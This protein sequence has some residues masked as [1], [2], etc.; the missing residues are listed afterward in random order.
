MIHKS[1]MDYVKSRLERD[2]IERVSSDGNPVNDDT[3][4]GVVKTG[5]LQGDPD[6][7]VAR[8]SVELYE[9]DPDQEI[10][11][12]GI[13]QTSEA[14]QDRIEEIEIGGGITWRRRFTVKVRVL[15]E[16]TREDLDNARRI[17]STVRSRVEKSILQM[18]FAGVA[19]E[20]EMV[21]MGPFSDDLNS[22]MLQAGG[23]PDAYDF[24]IKIRFE[25]L[26]TQF[27][28]EE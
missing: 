21:V 4:A 24:F 17:A 25:V 26:T 2:L 6:P 27:I 9:N 20:G 15:L 22:E 18:R 8:I 5:P 1:I 23:P 14:W 13:S 7:D 12:S 3:V 11:G 16:G 28:V 10:K 19:S